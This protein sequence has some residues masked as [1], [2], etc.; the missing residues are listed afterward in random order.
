[1]GGGV[2]S[3]RVHGVGGCLDGSWGGWVCGGGVYGG[4]DGWRVHGVGA[5]THP[6]IKSYNVKMFNFMNTHPPTHQ[7]YPKCHS[8]TIH[9]LWMVHGVGGGWWWGGWRVHGV[10][11]WRIHGVGGGGVIGGFIGWVGM[12]VMGWVVGG[13]MGWVGVWWWGG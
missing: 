2:G 3:W 5:Y 7:T 4:V 10:G 8:V 11:G 12:W 13:F 9:I 1:M 6:P